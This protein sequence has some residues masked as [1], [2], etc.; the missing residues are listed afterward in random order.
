MAATGSAHVTRPPSYPKDGTYADLLFWHL[1]V[2]GTRPDSSVAERPDTRWKARDFCAAVFGGSVTPDSEKKSYGSWIGDEERYAPGN[3]YALKIAKELFGGK[4]KFAVWEDDLERARKKSRGPGK[5]FRTITLDSALSELA[6]AGLIGGPTHSTPQGAQPPSARWAVSNVPVLVPRHF[7]GRADPIA[8]IDEFL[9][10]TDPA[11]VALHGIAGVGKTSLAAAYATSRRSDYIATWWVRAQSADQIKSDLL[12]LAQALGWEGTAGD[13]RRVL[14]ELR[15]NREPILLIFD[16]AI[17]ARDLSPYL[18]RGGRAHI[19]I[20]ANAPDWRALAEPIEIDCWEPEVGAEYLIARTGHADERA[21]AIRLSKILG[22][23]P[24]AHEQAGSYCEHLGI[25][26][27]EY[28]DLIY[29]RPAELLDSDD[30]SATEYHD[31]TPLARMIG[32]GF[33]AAGEM[34]AGALDLFVLAAAL[35]CEPIPLYLFRETVGA[36]GRA[37]ATLSG[38]ELEKA[39]VAL[40]TFG[41]IYREKDRIASRSGDV[42][43][44]DVIRFHRL[45][46]ALAAGSISDKAQANIMVCWLRAF[47]QIFRT[48]SERPL[49]DRRLRLLTPFYMPLL[50]SAAD[51]DFGEDGASLYVDFI[52]LYARYYSPDQSPSRGPTH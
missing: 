29:S 18:P 44:V 19:I 6:A 11:V 5:N 20:T 24:L 47:V 42:V 33:E 38:V 1:Y 4:S 31:G 36:F 27:R 17:S 51:L 26:F 13:Y 9:R 41:L 35:P 12:G 30:Y 43:E 32:L 7:T 14:D 45:V 21:N 50:A 52:H 23:L 8:K 49:R 10:A 37:E 28:S 34:H 40:Q 3:S 16:N 39:I 48:D 46:W 15:N 2:W 25:S 22:G